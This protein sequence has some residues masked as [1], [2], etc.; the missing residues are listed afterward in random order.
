MR[1][2]DTRYYVCGRAKVRWVVRIVGWLWVVVSIALILAAIAHASNHVYWEFVRQPS[3][4]RSARSAV[5]TGPNRKLNSSPRTLTH[6][7]CERL[8]PCLV[9]TC[10]NSSLKRCDSARKSLRR[11]NARAGNRP[12]VP[13]PGSDRESSTDLILCVSGLTPVAALQPKTTRPAFSGC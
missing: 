1:T 3:S 13:S 7:I 12:G 4:M 10:A 11:Q 2:P 5:V 6:L 8:H 9:R